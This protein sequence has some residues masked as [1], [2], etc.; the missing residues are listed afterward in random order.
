MEPYQIAE[1]SN[2]KD[3]LRNE[4]KQEMER[5]LRMLSDMVANEEEIL[6]T[7]YFTII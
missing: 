1:M 5:I 7:N 3:R 6:R 2:E 4:E